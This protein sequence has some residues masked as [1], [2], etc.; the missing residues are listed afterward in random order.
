MAVHAGAAIP[1]TLTHFTT[2]GGAAGIANTGLNAS[3]GGLFGGGRYA[4]STGHFPTNPLVPRGATVPVTISNTSG[5]VR[6][7]PGTFVQPTASGAAQLGATQAAYGGLANRDMTLG[8][9]DKCGQ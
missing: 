1:K 6:A 2:A 5:Y 4:S 9:C 8:G 3:R 7:V